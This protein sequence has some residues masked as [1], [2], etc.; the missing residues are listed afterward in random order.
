MSKPAFQFFF[1][2]EPQYTTDASR[3]IVASLLRSYRRH[4]TRYDLRRIG[5]HHY[6]V[7]RWNSTAIAAARD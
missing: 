2:G 7:Q 5:P 4:P 3:S 1:V 6:T